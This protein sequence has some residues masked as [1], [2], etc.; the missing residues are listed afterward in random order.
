MANAQTI[1]PFSLF[2][3]VSYQ[4]SIQSFPV[5]RVQQSA[6]T[7]PVRPDQAA[8]IVQTQMDFLNVYPGQAVNINLQSNTP[9]GSPL[10]QIAMVYVNN[11]LNN[12][13]LSIYFPDTQQLIGIPAFTSGYYPVMTGQLV[14]TV[15]NGNTGKVPVAS[16]SMCQIIFCNFAMPGFLSEFSVSVNV[17]SSS[18][19][20]IPSIGDKF[21]NVNAQI[22]GAATPISVFQL[23][24]TIALPQQYVI[25]G[26]NVEFA[27]LYADVQGNMGQF[28]V[29]IQDPTSLDVLRLWTVNVPN[30]LASYNSFM[31][32]NED[33][34]NIPCQGLQA[35]LQFGA[36][37][38]APNGNGLFNLTYALVTL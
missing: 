36:G 14:A 17:N 25:T 3:A 18:G 22:T 24:P 23:L 1:F 29:E 31:L 15:Y 12:Q 21:V 5:S 2:M 11:E 4:G 26:I 19:L 7:G 9:A 10:S 35:A 30:S 27:A 37:N 8:R 34:L 20:I 6:A 33:G 28:T 32:S 38:S 13:D 16:T